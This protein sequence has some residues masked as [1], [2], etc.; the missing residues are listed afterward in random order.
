M[1]STSYSYRNTH[2]ARYYLGHRSIKLVVVKRVDR[3]LRCYLS[4]DTTVRCLHR[5]MQ[6]SASRA[7]ALCMLEQIIEIVIDFTVVVSEAMS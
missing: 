2:C 6:L 5:D 7:Y 4:R 1:D 3:K